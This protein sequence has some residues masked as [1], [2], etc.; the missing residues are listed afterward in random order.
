MPSTTYPTTPLCYVVTTPE[1]SHIIGYTSSNGCQYPIIECNEGYYEHYGLCL[2]EYI[3]F[4]KSVLSR[5][6]RKT[7]MT[8]YNYSINYI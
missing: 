1:N 4:T 3:N 6:L 5:L 2:G 7:K 8:I